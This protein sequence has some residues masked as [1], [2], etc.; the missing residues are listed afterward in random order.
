[1]KGSSSS[2]QAGDASERRQSAPMRGTQSVR[3]GGSHA[4]R[5]NQNHLPVA[6]HWYHSAALP[7]TTSS[8][9]RSFTSLPCLVLPTKRTMVHSLSASSRTE[10][11]WLLSAARWSERMAGWAAPEVSL[12]VVISVL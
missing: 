12:L 8:S 11:A 2:A 1:M 6:G 10:R 9:G 7:T 5:G 3:G 4:E